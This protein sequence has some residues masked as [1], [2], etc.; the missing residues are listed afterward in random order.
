MKDAFGREIKVGDTLVYGT[1]SGSSQQLNVAI[2]REVV[3][4]K[5]RWGDGEKEFVRAE[6]VA[7]TDSDFFNGKMKWTGKDYVTETLTSRNVA[8]QASGNMMIA[9]GLDVEQ[10]KAICTQ[11]QADAARER[12]ERNSKRKKSDTVEDDE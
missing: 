5:E 8:L 4:K 6:C 9:N 12:D 2:V 1:R 7:G 11:R 3:K 10:L